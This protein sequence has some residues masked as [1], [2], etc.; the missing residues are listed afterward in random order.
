[1]VLIVA[2]TNALVRYRAGSC[3]GGAH[4]K[5]AALFQGIVLKHRL[6]EIS[7]KLHRVRTNRFEDKARRVLK[8]VEDLKESENSFAHKCGQ[9]GV[10]RG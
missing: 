3:A 9:N 7:N 5:V 1:M 4:C 8:R 6:R 2:F 10:I